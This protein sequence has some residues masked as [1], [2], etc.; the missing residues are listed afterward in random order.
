MSRGWGT[1]R[2][3]VAAMLM[4]A[5]A[6]VTAERP[7]GPQPAERIVVEPLGFVPPS[8]FYKSYR[9]PSAT[10]DFLDADHLLFTFHIAKLMHREK[11]DPPEDQ[12][13]QVRALVLSVP[14]GRVESEG[15]WR[16]HDH[17]PYVWPLR[18]GFFLMR[19]R[20][21]LFVGD[22]KLTLK[23]YL[24]PEGNLTSVQLSPDASTLAVQ[25]WKPS[26]KAQE[27]TDATLG[28]GSPVIFSGPSRE[29]QLLLVDTRAKVARRV[30]RVPHPLVFP[31]V[32]GGFLDVEQ[33]KGKD[34][35][36]IV[37]DFTGGEPHFIANVQSPCQPQLHP[38]S[39][40]MFLAFTCLPF[41]S[42]HLVEA[43]TL[44]GKMLWQQLWQS[45][46]AWGTYSYTTSGNR[47]AYGTVEVNHDLSPL[48]PVDDGSIVG[49]PVGVFSLANGKLDAVVDASPILTAG[50]NFALSPDGSRFAVLRGGA[51]ELYTLPKAEAPTVH[52]APRGEARGADAIPL[53]PGQP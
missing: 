25:Y 29:Y 53:T 7:Q 27:A 13:Q 24:H 47:F 32:Q 41:S 34:W 18:D 36:V 51:I 9:V 44:D 3:F 11:D 8:A 4:A 14:G 52:I 2:Q 22:G 40:Q 10:L 19:Q 49:Q 1:F 37:R 26:E 21:T 15:T 46:F 28:D 50:D 20:N 39:E 12:D 31:L 43:Y 35:R 45:R 23:P 38:L 30:G 42:D 16:L 5:P 6:V 33:G 17:G 48:D